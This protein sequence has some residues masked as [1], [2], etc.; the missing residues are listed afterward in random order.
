[1]LTNISAD[2]AQRKEWESNV[3]S[4]F[5]TD[6][7]SLNRH[8]DSFKK[9]ITETIH[10]KNVFTDEWF[11]ELKELIDNYGGTESFE[12][13]THTFFIAYCQE[14]QLFNNNFVQELDHY[15]GVISDKLK[16]HRIKSFKDKLGRPASRD[17]ANY[18]G[19]LYEII[20]VG[21]FAEKGYLKE[22]EP[23]LDDREYRPEA[24]VDISGQE[25]L[26]EATVRVSSRKT[27]LTPSFGV[28]PGAREAIRKVYQKIKEKID[29]LKNIKVPF[30]LFVNI[31]PREVFPIEGNREIINLVK[32]E[33]TFEYTSAVM[34]SNF[35]NRLDGGRIYINQACRNPLNCKSI[36][37][38]KEIFKLENDFFC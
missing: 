5:S 1:M 3:G 33:S 7:E 37:E 27:S 35:Y 11:D 16:T 10:L 15:Y 12:T 20:I 30:I 22:Y 38:I 24:K 36:V 23:I 31:D 4:I 26:I 28:G 18:L 19:T 9:E 29:K 8:F 21:K 2:E 32:T 13:E 34:M 17:Y 6:K 14:F 25:I